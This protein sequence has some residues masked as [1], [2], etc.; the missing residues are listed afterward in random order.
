MN[1]TFLNILCLHIFP[2][3][4]A[5]ALLFPGRENA[6]IES[7]DAVVRLRGLVSSAFTAFMAGMNGNQNYFNIH[8]TSVPGGE[9]RGFL[10][11]VPEPTSLGLLALGTLGIL[12]RRR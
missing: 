12:S 7:L 10:V 11:A 4:G 5:L 1:L 3:P 6:G 9:I 2:M 8:T